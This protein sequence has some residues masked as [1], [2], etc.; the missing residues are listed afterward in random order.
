MKD[1]DEREIWSFNSQQ[2]KSYQ[3]F[4]RIPQNKYLLGL[5]EKYGKIDKNTKVLE[6]G[7]GW[8]FF[9]RKLSEKAKMVYGIDFENKM[10]KTCRNM[11]KGKKNIR[12]IKGD[13]RTLP[14]KDK[15]FDLV[16]CFGVVEHFDESVEAIKELKRVLKKGGKLIISVPSAYNIT[17]RILRRIAILRKK[18]PY[19]YQKH[20]SISSFKNILNDADVK[21]IFMGGYG[22]GLGVIPSRSR[23]IK[24]FASPLEDFLGSLVA[25]L[26]NK[27]SKIVPYF[28]HML[29]AVCS[30]E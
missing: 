24:F 27:K 7:C 16:L 6:A 20:Y 21:I 2:K 13:V 18:V 9:V 26:Q 19:Y 1:Y 8:G 22:G 3:A 25:Y 14:F 28:T 30:S 11:C 12:L 23:F 5:I 15:T 29:V 4:F 10:L 17:G